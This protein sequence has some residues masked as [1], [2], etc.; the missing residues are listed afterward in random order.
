[1]NI[2]LSYFQHYPHST[3]LLKTLTS[4][5]KF[6]GKD[7]APAFFAVIRDIA[8]IAFANLEFNDENYV[9]ELMQLF[10]VTPYICCAQLNQNPECITTILR[11]ADSYVNTAPNRAKMACFS[12]L[13]RLV[14]C[15]TDNDNIVKVVTSLAGVFLTVIETKL[16]ET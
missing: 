11:V 2:L 8:N 12:L 16:H 9:R 6:Y 4:L 10:A 3:V 7:F 14:R 5:T 15:E 1:M 13:N